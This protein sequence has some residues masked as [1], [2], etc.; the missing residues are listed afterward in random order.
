MLFCSFCQLFAAFL[1]YCHVLERGGR[2]VLKFLRRSVRLGC[3]AFLVFVFT[4]Y[5]GLQRYILYVICA[6]GSAPFFKGGGSVT[7]AGATLRCYDRVCGLIPSDTALS[8]M[9]FVKPI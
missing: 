8:L 4:L 3:V 5:L 6:R 2:D 7:A 1:E 9:H